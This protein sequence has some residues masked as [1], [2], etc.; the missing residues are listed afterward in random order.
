MALEVRDCDNTIILFCD[1]RLK[2]VQEE[3]ERFC[4]YLSTEPE[5]AFN[6]LHGAPQVT[7]QEETSYGSRTWSIPYLFDGKVILDGV[8]KDDA[9]YNA[10][11]YVKAKGAR[12]LITL[13]EE[14]DKTF[15]DNVNHP[16]HYQTK[17]G[18]EVIDVIE[19]FIAD[20]QGIVAFDIGNALKYL[21]RWKHKGGVEDLKKAKWYIDH[22]IEMESKD[23]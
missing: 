17:N 5:L 2:A 12:K 11:Y 6:T 10:Y 22:A 1:A 9:I 14:Q 7:V 15:C 19:A 20:L 18:I 13:A 23:E 3:K 16:N 21:C 4:L 8:A